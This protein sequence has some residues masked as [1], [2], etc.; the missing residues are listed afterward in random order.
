MSIS[1]NLKKSDQ[2]EMPEELLRLR[3]RI[4]RLPRSIREELQPLADRAIEDAIFRGRV[5]NV[6]KDGLKRYQL[7]V[8]ALRLD[9]ERARAE[10]EALLRELG[11][12]RN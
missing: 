3:A 1:M 6:A 12:S 2:S 7:D 10:R 8:N 9:L 5:L 4:E 11:A